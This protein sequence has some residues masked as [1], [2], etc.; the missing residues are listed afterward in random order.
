MYTN[1][2]FEDKKPFDATNF[3]SPTSQPS[4][5]NSYP[6]IAGIML[7]IAGIIGMAFWIQ[8]YLID[9]SMIELIINN[10]NQ[11]QGMENSLTEEQIIGLLQTC[12]IIGVIISIF[13]ILGGILAVKKKLY[14]IALTGSIIGLFSIGIMFSSSVL[15]LIAL[16]L[17][18]FSKTE[19][20]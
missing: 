17:L 20:Q 11:I 10:I 16:V 1:S 5:K 14:Y 8:M 19:F 3:D 4:N 7:I 12:A 15:S 6:L 13:P 2:G 9:A 18:I